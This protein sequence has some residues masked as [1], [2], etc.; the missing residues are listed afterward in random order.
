MSKKQSIK[1]RVNYKAPNLFA[2]RMEELKTM[3][4]EVLTEGKIDFD[5]LK[6]ALGEET[7]GKPERYS[8]TWAGK[9]DA[10]RL[11]QVP[12]R[13]SLV[14]D[15]DE[16]VNFDTTQNIFIEGDNLEV[17]K[18]LWKP[19]FGRI[20]MIY[21][22]PPYNRGADVIYQDD[23]T[24]PLGAYLTLT[25]QKDVQGNLLTSNPDTSGRY[26]S[27]WLSMLYPRLFFARQLLQDDG[28]IFVSIDDNEVHNLR[29]LMNEIFGEENFV[30]QITARTNPRGRTLDPFIAKTHE[31]LLI[32]A[33]NANTNALSEIPKTPKALAEYDKQDE[34]GQYR[35]LELRNRNPMFNRKNR[36]H[37][38]YPIYV[39]PEN[40][41]VSL[42]KQEEFHEEVYPLNSKGEEGCWTW[43]KE[44]AVSNSHMLVGKKVATGAW[45][46]FRKDYLPE[47]GATTKE[48]SIWLD[49]TINHENGKE[50]LGRLFDIT[51]FDF[52]KSVDLMKKCI[53][54]G[55]EKSSQDLVLDF[56][57]GSCTTAQAVMEMN[58]GDNGNRK[59]IM[60]QLPEP[61]PEDSATQKA[62]YNTIADIGKE[63]IRRVIAKMKKDGEGKL[64]L[65][66]PETPEDLGFKVF[67]LTESNSRPWVGV[68]EKDPEEYA[69][70]M[71]LYLDPLVEGWKVENVIYEAALKEGYSLTCRI[72]K[73]D[74]VTKNTIWKVS[75]DDKEQ[76]FHICLDEKIDEEAVKA[77]ELNTD[78]LFICRDMALTDELAANLALQCNLKVI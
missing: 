7:D 9:K 64:D 40:N 71:E 26:H 53:L 74:K 20:K 52:P 17:L 58:R 67:K 29:L 55:T 73:V 49:K 75:D 24:D 8:F 23:Y 39:N 68:E 63:R 65:G 4:P 6:T 36:P 78:N 56:M 35:E 62:G 47:E 18:L 3:F 44:K 16:S 57:A 33:R 34:H 42:D 50:E 54:L 45:R 28:V 69:K 66:N 61:T 38:F 37:M 59:F 14:P 32:F 1:K 77:L 27:S 51:P 25:S 12:N 11:L 21:I 13:A 30:A 72:E 41:G 31:F 15:K 76:S 48:K 19:Y 10:I 22:D 2:E 60:I 43:G 46:I 70:Q 5:K